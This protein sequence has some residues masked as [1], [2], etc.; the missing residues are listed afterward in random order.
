MSISATILKETDILWKALALGAI[1][2]FVYD[3]LRI[4][5]RLKRH[6]TWWVALEDFLFWMGSAVAI[7]SML[8]REDDGYLRGFS[9]GGVVLGM[10]LYAG[11]LSPLVVKGGVFVLKKI[12][13]VLT[14]PLV[15]VSRL[16]KIPLRAIRRQ[17]KK[18]MGFLKKRLKKI[19]KT[20][21]IR[22]CKR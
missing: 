21:K 6:G 2:M 15:W 20:V 3:M 9:I 18:I 22:L 8:F 10:L 12:A 14:R 4:L 19:R 17:G 5:R 13:F 16:F 11:T 7:F 1:L